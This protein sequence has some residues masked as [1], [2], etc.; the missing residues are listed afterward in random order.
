[1]RFLT[2]IAFFSNLE[3]LLKTHL[4]Y[5]NNIKM[6]CFG[7]KTAA[8]YPTVK[9]KVLP[10]PVTA[11]YPNNAP[12]QIIKID[13]SKQYF[14]LISKEFSKWIWCQKQP[15]LLERLDF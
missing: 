2:K 12:S 15:N 7:T 1:M 14:N 9:M 13:I 11:F 3:I 10:V 8:K 6:G 5:H 4:S